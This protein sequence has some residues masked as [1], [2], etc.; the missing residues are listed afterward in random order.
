M[1]GCVLIV[2]DN[3]DGR[4]VLTLI[5]SLAGYR[6]PQAANG[7]EAVAIARAEKPT[8]IVMDIYMPLMDGI[9]ATQTLKREA[10]VTDIPV[11][12]Q[13]AMVS[14]VDGARD[15]FFAV[16]QKPCNPDD[17][18]AMVASAVERDAPATTA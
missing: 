18:L 1:P 9:S 4:E 7:L 6:T 11:I 15:L 3:D 13:T 12:A 16:V 2:D 17:L 10:D 14:A 8:V 5:L